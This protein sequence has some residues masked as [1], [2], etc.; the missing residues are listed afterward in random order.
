MNSLT[1]HDKQ[2]RTKRVVRQDGSIIVK[3]LD[4]ISEINTNETVGPEDDDIDL[5]NV[6]YS[7]IET[8]MLNYDLS[9]DLNE[10]ISD[11]SIKFHSS[12]I[13]QVRC[14]LVHLCKFELLKKHRKFCNKSQNYLKFNIVARQLFFKSI[15]FSRKY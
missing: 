10:L 13:N 11:I 14:I 4:F 6:Q 2:S 3:P 12:V 5:E 8:F 7:K 15:T 9:Y 1:S